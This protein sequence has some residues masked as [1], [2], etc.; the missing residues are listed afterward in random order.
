V[1]R[2]SAAALK[3]LNF[4]AALNPGTLLLHLILYMEMTAT[5]EFKGALAHFN[6]RKDNAGLY[7]ASLTQY[8]GN[9]SEAPPEEITILRGIR[10]WTGSYN[11]DLLLSRLGKMIE[12]RLLNSIDKDRK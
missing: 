2:I 3:T 5:V 8:D 1:I 9:P 7:Y 6:I 11:D 10:Q 12:D 4:M